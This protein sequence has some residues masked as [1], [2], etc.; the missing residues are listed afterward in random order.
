MDTQLLQQISKYNLQ[1]DELDDWYKDNSYI[2]GAYR[3]TNEGVL[4]YLKSIFKCHNE[5]VNIW[6]HLVGSLVFIFLLL[7]TNISGLVVYPLEDSIAINVYLLSITACFS[8]STIMHTFYPMSNKCCKNLCRL[9]YIGI[10]LFI[11]GSYGPFIHF[12]FYC[13][14]ILRWTYYILINLIGLICI[15]LTFIPTFHKSKFKIYRVFMFASLIVACICPIIHRIL[16]K[17]REEIYDFFIELEY[18]ILSIVFCILG[19]I[20]FVSKFPEKHYPGKFDK[21][22]SSHQIFHIFSILAGIVMYLGIVL[23][24]NSS[25]NISC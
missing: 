7:Y 10:S 9:D 16:I 11:L 6:T 3:K 15:V 1:Y 24:H 19:A 22:L 2:H 4:F 23:T 17:D 21:I 5:T 12:A 25:K 8:F 13:N 18:Y 20:F 14:N